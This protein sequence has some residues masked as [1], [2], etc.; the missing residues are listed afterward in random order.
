MNSRNDLPSLAEWKAADLVE[1]LSALGY[2]PT[3]IRGVNYW[4]LSPLREE[5]TASFKVNRQINRWY[6]FGTGQGGSLIDFGIRYYHCTVAEFLQKINGD[7]AFEKHTI[8]SSIISPANSLQVTSSESKISIVEEKPLT[9][10]ALLRYLWQRG[11]PTQIAEP[12]CRQV[13]Y[14]IGDKNYYG[15]GFG[16]DSG[17]YEIRNRYQ[18]LSSSPKDITTIQNGADQVQVLEGFMDFLSLLTIRENEPTPA[19]D[20]VILNSVSLF[21]K[22]RPFLEQYP[23]IR[24]YLDRDTAGQHCTTHALSLGNKYTDESGL[25]QHYKDVNDWLVSKKLAQRKSTKVKLG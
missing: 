16:N 7:F 5:R 6:D 13:H 24:L 4:Y 11:I 10:F 9:C 8:F 12:F 18:K 20:F 3:K 22:A 23:S 21:E 25:Y 2:E 15:I 1:Y 14:Q 17:G 19:T